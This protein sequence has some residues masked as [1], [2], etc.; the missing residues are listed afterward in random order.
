MTVKKP[1]VWKQPLGNSADTQELVESSNEEASFNGLFPEIMEQP[2]ADGGYPPKRTE[3]NALFKDIGEHLYYHQIGGTSEYSESTEYPSNAVVS[4]KGELYLCLKQNTGEDLTNTQ[5]W[6]KLVTNANAYDTVNDRFLP[7]SGGEMFDYSDVSHLG[8]SIHGDITVSEEV[9]NGDEDDHETF[10]FTQSSDNLNFVNEQGNKKITLSS[11]KYTSNIDLNLTFYDDLN[12]RWYCMLTAT[13]TPKT[14]VLDT[15]DASRVVWILSSYQPTHDDTETKPSVPYFN[16]TNVISEISLRSDDDFE[17]DATV[18]VYKLCNCYKNVV[19]VS[20]KWNA[21]LIKKYREDIDKNTTDIKSNNETITKALDDAVADIK[22]TH[23]NLS[24]EQTISGAKTF[25]TIPKSVTPSLGTLDTSVATTKWVEDYISSHWSSTVLEHNNVCREANLLDGHFSS[26]SDIISAVQNGEFNDIYVGDYFPVTYT[27]NGSSVTS[28]MRIAGINFFTAGTGE[29]GVH[30]NHVC[31]VPDT[32]ITSYMNSTN[33]TSGGYVGSYMYTTTIPNIYNALA[34][35]SG[36]P[37]YGHVPEMYESLVNSVNTSAAAGSGIS[38]WVGAATGWT[39][40]KQRMVL[41]SES[42]IYGFRNFG[43]AADNIRCF[44]QLPMFKL[45]HTLINMNGTQWH[46]LR[47]V[48]N[49]T[50]F[51][52]ASLSM[53]ARCDGASY[54]THVR[55]RFVIS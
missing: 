44:A 15:T 52:N 6:T 39:D 11:V 3:F 10:V 45:D 34:G 1:S 17:N 20:E 46:W 47:S 42:E 21:S 18:T 40:I 37:F 36:T 48:A 26:V 51:C 13:D 49:N 14:L 27:I 32:T 50:G 4:Y 33:T 2:L 8:Y 31:I 28:N 24:G 53:H 16:D 41:M 7:L 35:S 12:W 30:T 55:P 22:D 29:W 9:Y 23:V 43:T 25:S 19:T 38:G 5:Y 54:V